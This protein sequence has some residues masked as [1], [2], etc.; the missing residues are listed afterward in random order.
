MKLH[1]GRARRRVGFPQILSENRARQNAFNETRADVADQRS[2][3]I[4]RFERES[5]PD[6]RRFL[7]ERSENAARQFRLVAERESKV[8]FLDFAAVAKRDRL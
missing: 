5:R 1:V 7:S 3:K 8:R 2:D 4:P 6:R